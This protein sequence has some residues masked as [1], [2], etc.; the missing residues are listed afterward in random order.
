MQ[1]SDPSHNPVIAFLTDFGLS[2][3][4]VA[5]MHA[6]ALGITPQARLIDISHAIPPQRITDGAWTLANTYRYFP[7]STVFVC[8]VDPGVGSVRRPLAL[9]AGDWYFV[10]PDNGL[11]SYILMQQPVHKAVALQ[12]SAYHLQ[13]ISSTFHGRDIFSP[14]A[15]YLARGVTLDDLGPA[16]DPASLVRLPLQPAHRDGQHVEG[17]VAHI[18]HFGNLLTNIPSQLVPEL[19]HAPSVSL[20]IANTTIRD[21]QRYFADPSQHTGSPFIFVDSSNYLAI[22]IRNGNAARTLNVSCDTPLSL[23]IDSK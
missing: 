6:V 18:D 13:N 15:A 20:T 1:Q 12:N 22:A 17:S 9:H 23:T 5:V 14:V 16:L 21:R 7:P 11:F 19:F 10:G 3:G 8:V 4:F 2:D